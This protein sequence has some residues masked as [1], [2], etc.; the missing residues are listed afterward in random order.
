MALSTNY[1]VKHWQNSI[2]TCHDSCNFFRASELCFISFYTSELALRLLVHRQYFFCNADQ[3][4][5]WFD[6]LLVFHGLYDQLMV[7]VLTSGASRV[8]LTFM[9][10]V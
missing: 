7:F 10:I 5:N 8:N 4:W 9:R 6:F 1:E 2:D 3:A